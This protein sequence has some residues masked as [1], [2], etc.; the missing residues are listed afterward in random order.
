MKKTAN[1]EQ[2]L[3]FFW[4]ASLLKLTTASLFSEG[5]FEVPGIAV[6]RGRMVYAGFGIWRR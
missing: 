6:Q 1:R 5:L 3:I 2:F 4:R